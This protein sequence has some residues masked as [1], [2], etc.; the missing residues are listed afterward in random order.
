MAQNTQTKL[1]QSIFPD[2]PRGEKIVTPEGELT[3]VW[4]L[5]IASLYQALQRNFN[6]EGLQIPQLDTDQINYIQNLYTPFIGLPLPRY[7]PNIAGKKVYDYILSEEKTFILS[8][9]IPG[10]FSSNITV[11]QWKTVTLV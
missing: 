4:H 7:L 6:N 10:N 1:P 2:F 5:S 3:R 11:A 9:S 8:F